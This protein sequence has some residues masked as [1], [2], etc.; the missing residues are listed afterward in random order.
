[1]VGLIRGYPLSH[2]TASLLRTGLVHGWQWLEP[3]LSLLRWGS[4]WAG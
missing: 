2:S 3:V 1:M 4:G